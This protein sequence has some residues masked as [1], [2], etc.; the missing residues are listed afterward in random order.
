MLVKNL[1]LTSLTLASSVL[2][3]SLPGRDSLLLQ[4]AARATNP[5]D[6]V[7]N[8]LG[9]TEIDWINDNLKPLTAFNG[10]KCDACKNKLKYGQQ[11]V[12]Y[13]HLDVYK[14]QVLRLWH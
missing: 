14:R 13:T 4:L 12:S 7:Y 5:I 9:D 6:S 3:H 2:G 10:T 8:D 11:S 1:V